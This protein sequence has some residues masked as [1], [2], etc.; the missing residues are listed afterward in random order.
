MTKFR[1][2]LN[3]GTTWVVV[4]TTLPYNIPSLATETVTAERIG[5]AVTLGPAPIPIPTPFSFALSAPYSPTV[6]RTGAG[7]ASTFSTNYNF[8]SRKSLVT[9]VQTIYVRLAGNNNND[10][11]TEGAAIRSLDLAVRMANAYGTATK[12][13]YQ[14]AVLGSPRPLFRRANSQARTG[15]I[16]VNGINIDA[17]YN[18][19]WNGQ[20]A[21]VDIVFEPSVPNGLAASCVDGALPAAVTTSDPNIYRQTAGSASDM[22]DFTNLDEKGAP[23]R[24]ALVQGTVANSAAPWPEI[25]A[26]WNLYSNLPKRGGGTYNTGVVCSTANGVY[27]RTWDNRNPNGDSFIVNGS[28]IGTAARVAADTTDRRFVCEGLNFIGGL[29]GAL[30][31]TGT[32]NGRVRADLSRCSFHGSGGRGAISIQPAQTSSATQGV[33]VVAHECVA[34]GGNLDG[35]S[36]DFDATL[37]TLNCTGDWNGWTTSGTNNGITFHGTSRG[38]DVNGS[39]YN[40]QDRSVHHVHFGQNWHLGTTASTRRGADGTTTSMVYA[41]NDTGNTGTRTIWMDNCRVVNG[42]NGAAQ[43]TT[44]SGSSSVIYYANMV[45]TPGPNPAGWTGTFTPYT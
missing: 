37:V 33:D 34:S 21:T 24:L 29:N 39:Y 38:L 32:N 45:F 17:T 13:N 18:D 25:N 6:Y 41:A 43:W 19:C 11:L 7:T 23:I 35:W 10:G 30:Q 20:I 1:Y 9:P 36:V 26:L 5:A 4:D 28:Q 22:W 42:P 40:N 16:L 31:I 3:G 14:S 12:I 15:S 8:A 2:T 44:G 27:I